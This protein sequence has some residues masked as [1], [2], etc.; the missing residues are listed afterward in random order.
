MDAYKLE[1]W[2]TQLKR[3]IRLYVREMSGLVEKMD[4]IS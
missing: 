2:G 1:R 3:W 4:G